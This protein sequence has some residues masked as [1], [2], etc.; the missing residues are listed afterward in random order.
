MKNKLT[1]GFIFLF[2]VIS[3][4]KKGDITNCFKGTGEI[5]TEIRAI[6]EVSFIHLSNNVNLIL[7]QDSTPFIRV[8]AGEKIINSII[9]EWK[10]NRL[11]IRNENGCNWV[12]SYLKDINVYVGVQ[13]IDSIEYR[14]SGNIISTNTII[15]DSIKI[16]IREGSGSIRMDLNVGKS[17]LYL[18]YGSC[19]LHMTGFS[20]VTHIYAASYGPFFCQDLYSKFIYITNKGTNDCYINVSEEL[21]AKIEYMGNIYYYG[22]PESVATELTG[23]GQLIKLD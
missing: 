22:N 15:N 3:S 17:E 11:Y 5:T 18:H 7:T 21:Y 14:G 9:T 10:E 20:G 23:S 19:D 6:G 12:R 13:S 4:C 2:A 8:E 16:D 1:I